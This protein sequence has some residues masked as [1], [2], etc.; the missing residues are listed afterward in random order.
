M[1]DQSSTFRTHPQLRAQRTGEYIL[2]ITYGDTATAEGAAAM[3][4][5]IHS[6]LTAV[7]PES[8]EEY[9][10][11][12]PD[13]LLWVHNTLTWSTVR[14]FEAYGEG[15]T[16]RE[17]DQYVLEQHIAARL[18]GCDVAQVASTYDELDR[19]V[20]Q[21]LPLLAFTTE[22]I[23]FRDLM[24][25]KG[26]QKGLQ[27]IVGQALARAAVGTMAD[28]HRRLYGLAWP[29]WRDAVD[30]AAA[31]AIFKGIRSKISVPGI[32]AELDVKA[33][34]ARNAPAE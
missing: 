16:A 2:I 17:R 24:V 28:D 20:E 21:Q 6:R 8:G 13:Y 7:D 34:G 5:R 32:R 15:L 31:A 3:L 4:H 26:P 22:A 12:V 23:W 30:H 1:I 10:V 25:P 14:G 9:G 29:K 27:A 19:W 18:V 33:F 11:L